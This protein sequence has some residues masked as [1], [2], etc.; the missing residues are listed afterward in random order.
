MSVVIGGLIFAVIGHIGMRLRRK[1]TEWEEY[2]Q[3]EAARVRQLSH[4]AD[5]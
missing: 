5:N 4:Y 1:P 3:A 2:Q